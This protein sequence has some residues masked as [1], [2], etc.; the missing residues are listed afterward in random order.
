MNLNNNK[1]STE[2]TNLMWLQVKQTPERLL[3][4]LKAS[5]VYLSV[6]TSQLQAE[7]TV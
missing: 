1:P 7:I 2:D 4:E 5:N 6:D 3:R